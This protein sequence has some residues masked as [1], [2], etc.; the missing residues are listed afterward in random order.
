MIGEH[1]ASFLLVLLEHW[2][3]LHNYR[4][5]L[6][7]LDRSHSVEYREPTIWC[8]SLQA[9]RF[10]HCANVLDQ[11]LLGLFESDGD[12][13]ELKYGGIGHERLRHRSGLYLEE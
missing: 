9:Q 10:L 8:Q 11:D 7:W 4:L 3:K 5:R 13:S 2:L 6:S 12:F 1:N